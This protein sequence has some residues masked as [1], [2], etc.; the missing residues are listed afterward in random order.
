M[1]KEIKEDMMNM[2]HQIDNIN[3]KIKDSNRN[4]R[5]ESIVTK[6]K[7][8]KTLERLIVDMSWQKKESEYVKVNQ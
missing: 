6:M 3:K 1:L 7:K 4:S 8:K 5:D 2:P